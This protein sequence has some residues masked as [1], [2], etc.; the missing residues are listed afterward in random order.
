MHSRNRRCG[1]LIGKG[2]PPEQAVK[3]IGAVVEGYYAA[4]NAKALADKMGV[5][6]PIAA[7]AYEVLYHGKDPHAVLT[8]LMTREKKHEIEDSWVYHAP[9]YRRYHLAPGGPTDLKSAGPPVLFQ[10]Q[11]ERAYRQARPNILEYLR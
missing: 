4:A 5:E 3:E 8:E 9:Q 6:M 11:F 7:A 1:I 10:F 2:T